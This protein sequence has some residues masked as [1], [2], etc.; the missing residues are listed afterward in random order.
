M[1]FV[2]CGHEKG[3]GL[4]VF[5]KSFICLD[6]YSQEMFH[7]F[8]YEEDLISTI[9]NSNLKAT[10][11][12][13]EALFLQSK[14][15]ITFLNKIDHSKTM[16]SL[17]AILEVITPED[18]LLTLPSAKDQIILDNNQYNGYTEFFRSRFN[19]SNLTMNFLSHDHNVLLLTDHVSINDV[20]KYLTDES[21]LEKVITTLD[22]L[23]ALR[24][25]R[26][27]YFSGIDP[28]CGESGLISKFDNVFVKILPILRQRYPHIIFSGPHPSDTLHL[29]YENSKEKLFIY[30]YHDQ[31][32]NP[33]K[34]RNGLIGVNLTLGLPFIRLSVDHGTAFD[35]YGKNEANYIGMIF[36][37][38]EIGKWQKKSPTKSEAL[39]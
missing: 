38:D 4:E 11:N 32:L 29:K 22:L 1:I 8:C 17:L 31:G 30:A 23:P 16:A 5:I 27:V 9:K 12:K 3:I 6:S 2:S 21:I 39:K 26:E 15:K 18:I 19:N 34:L 7:L 35:L 20:T 37:L 14:L 28:H 10:I 13:K 36:L 24:N 33:F 25:I